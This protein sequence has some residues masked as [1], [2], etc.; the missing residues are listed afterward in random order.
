MNIFTKITS[1]F[2]LGLLASLVNAYTFQKIGNTTYGSD[3][4][5]W[6]TIGNTTY[7]SDGTNYQK[8]GNFTYGSDGTRCQKIGAFTHCN[9]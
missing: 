8:I 9:K 4:T 7:G 2:F 6:Q 3:G 5:N 1:I